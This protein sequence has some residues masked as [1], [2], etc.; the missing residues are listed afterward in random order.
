MSAV[1]CSRVEINPE[2]LSNFA[3]CDYVLEANLPSLTR[4][5]LTQRQAA[6]PPP[7]SAGFICSRQS[8][9]IISGGYAHLTGNSLYIY[10]QTKRIRC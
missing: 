9:P 8:A 4:V 2:L 7:I 6:D 1:T 5:H 3:D 10:M